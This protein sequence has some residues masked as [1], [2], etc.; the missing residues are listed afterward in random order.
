VTYDL[1]K[2]VESGR[3]E[4]TGTDPR[5]RYTEYRI[6]PDIRLEFM[7]E[8]GL[9]LICGRSREPRAGVAADG[10]GNPR[11][12]ARMQRSRVAHVRSDLQP[13]SPHGCRRFHP[14]VEVKAEGID[15]RIFPNTDKEP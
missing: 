1:R 2:L 5:D 6:K 14:D 11:E 9:R 3:V 12:R 13:A 7:N 4:R 10:R 15:I 8:G